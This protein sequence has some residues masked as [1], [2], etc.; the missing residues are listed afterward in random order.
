MKFL[1]LC[2]RADYQLVSVVRCM[3]T[4]AHSTLRLTTWLN[5]KTIMFHNVAS[6]SPRRSRDQA[7]RTTAPHSMEPAL[8]SCGLAPAAEPALLAA[9][10]QR[11]SQT[12]RSSPEPPP[13]RP[14]LDPDRARIWA[15]PG[16]TQDRTRIEPDANAMGGPPSVRNSKLE[17]KGGLN[18]WIF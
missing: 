10:P 17:N 18:S 5:E 6:L 11:V 13:N 15:Q 4:L 7:R 16:P 9:V 12:I 8:L 14:R 3:R 1:Q 2:F